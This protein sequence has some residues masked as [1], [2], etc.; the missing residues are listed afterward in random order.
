MKIFIVDDEPM[1]VDV[2]RA[3]F[4]KLGFEVISSDNGTE[5]SMLI[6]EHK[7]DFVI[8]DLMLPDMSGE[9][10]CHEVR[11]FSNVPI[12]MLTAK[13]SE[14]DR[15]NGILLGADDYVTKPFSPREVVV[16]V[17]SILKR[18]HGFAD[19][20]LLS[21]NSGHLT[22]DTSKK[23]V[24]ISGELVT[25]TPIEFRLLNHISKHPGRVYSREEL[26]DVVQSENYEGAYERSIDVHIKNLRKK[27]EVDS[28]HPEFVMTVF[29]MGYK[30]GGKQDVTDLKL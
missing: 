20:H 3:Y 9:D 26:L 19:S 28:K 10:I 25:L 29:G 13:S 27:I 12:L 2:L 17:Q 22:I 16:R 8:L 18:V 4:Q 24:K 30:F 6:K 14:E 7:P 23:E 15:I 11:Q 5:A 21:F 1:I